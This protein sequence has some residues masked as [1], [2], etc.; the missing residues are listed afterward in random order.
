MAADFSPARAVAV[1]PEDM[2][3]KGV[4]IGWADRYGWHSSR[5]I[6]REAGLPSVAG[7]K[8]AVEPKRAA[9]TADFIMVVRFE[10]CYLSLL[11]LL[12]PSAVPCCCVSALN[13]L[14]RGNIFLGFAGSRG[15]TANYDIS[16]IEYEYPNS[17]Q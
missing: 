7:A 11:L 5:R 8:A 6:K 3:E 14:P 10:E 2:D 4:S 13:I 16:A 12:L 15:T 1:R 17:I 9:S